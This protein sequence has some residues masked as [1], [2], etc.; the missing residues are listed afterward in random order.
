MSDG[1]WPQSGL[2]AGFH[3][4]TVASGIR[5]AAR[6]TPRKVALR[7]GD[8]QRTFA[9]LV[10]AIDR[11][12][13]AAR[14]LG[15][16]AG[17]HAAIIAPNCLAYI[18]IVCGISELGAAIATP[19]PRLTARE[20]ADICNDAQAQIVFVHPDSL[21]YLDRS[22]LLTVRHVVVIGPEYDAL[23]QRAS[24]SFTPPACRMR[25][26]AWLTYTSDPADDRKSV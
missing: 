24:S 12:A 21:P 19:N 10:Q 4:L 13:N 9:Q 26:S 8:Q 7:C 20:L 6:R 23:L 17:Q 5:T 11:V 16:G 3:H 1:Q 14:G 15:L 25:P 18:E 22:L 2:P